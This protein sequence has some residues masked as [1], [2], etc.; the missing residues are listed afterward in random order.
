ME[1]DEASVITFDMQC[2]KTDGT[3]IYQM[4]CVQEEYILLLLL[5]HVQHEIEGAGAAGEEH[6]KDLSSPP[7]ALVAQRSDKA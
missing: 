1:K 2:C 3:A 7:Q 5:L 4:Y 6:M